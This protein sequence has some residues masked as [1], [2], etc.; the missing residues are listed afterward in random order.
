M[1]FFRGVERMTAAE[2]GRR[3][4]RVALRLLRR[5][6]YRVLARNQR[7]SFGE[8]D[9]VCLAPD[10]RE[11]V[12]VEVKTLRY[13]AGADR[14]FRPED[15]VTGVKRRRLRGLARAWLGR[16]GWPTRPWRI[17]VVAVE[18]EAGR[19]RAA[20]RHHIGAGRDQR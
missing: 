17:D 20:V 12:F 14:R 13:R 11:V 6:G 8:I 19:R 5:R 2:V 4:E 15:H 10:R 7:L 3:G 18:F 9:L 1:R 16:R